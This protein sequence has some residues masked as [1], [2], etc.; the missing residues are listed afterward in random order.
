[1]FNL[2][3]GFDRPDRGE[4]VEFDGATLDRIGAH[5]IAQ[6]GIVRT[7]QLTKA[8]SKMSVLDN[9]SLA[10]RNQT[11]EHLATSLFRRRWGD[12][13]REIE[14]RARALLDRFALLGA[15]PTT[16]ARSRAVSASCSRWRAR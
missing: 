13:E 14:R 5:R 2:L 7:F 16:R 4:W 15:P 11:G 1:M 10:A 8:L 12:Q 3:T 9:M 6:P